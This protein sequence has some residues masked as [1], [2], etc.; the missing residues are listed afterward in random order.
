M[1]ATSETIRSCIYIIYMSVYILLYYIADIGSMFIMDAYIYICF[2]H[3]VLIHLRSVCKATEA[4]TAPGKNLPQEARDA[5]LLKSTGSHAAGPGP[6][7][8]VALIHHTFM[9]F[10]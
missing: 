3:I 5:W 7:P 2:I 1:R 8:E 10:G 4:C 6:G 9:H